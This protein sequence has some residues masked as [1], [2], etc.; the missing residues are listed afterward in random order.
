MTIPEPAEIIAEVEPMLI[1]IRGALRHGIKKAR[2]YFNEEEEENP[3]PW[4]APDLVRWN[5]KRHLDRGGHASE[6]L[7][8]DYTRIPASN[9]GLRLTFKGFPIIVRKT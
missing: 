2:E 8:E 5:A 3:D 4:L 1:V 7:D 9:N 6:M